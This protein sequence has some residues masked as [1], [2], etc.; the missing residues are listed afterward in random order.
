M[1]TKDSKIKNVVV[2]SDYTRL[3]EKEEGIKNA[4]VASDGSPKTEEGDK[5]QQP[6]TAIFPRNYDPENKEDAFLGPDGE[7]RVF[8]NG[9]AEAND[10][11]SYVKDHPIGEPAITSLHPDWDYYS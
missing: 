10:V 8:L 3:T 4:I 7:L 1:G 9:L 2:A 11:P 6:N 5:K